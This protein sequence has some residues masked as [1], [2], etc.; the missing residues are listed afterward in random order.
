MN[1]ISMNNVFEIIPITLGHLQAYRD[2]IHDCTGTMHGYTAGY[3][4]RL[5]C[6]VTL[7]VTMHGYNER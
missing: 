4:A 7:Q 6:T 1:W 5:K 3:N 2:D